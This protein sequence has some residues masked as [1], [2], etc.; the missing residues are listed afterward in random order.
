MTPSLER[1]SAG[2][3]AAVDGAEPGLE[4]ANDLCSACVELLGMDGAAVSMIYEGVSRGTFG[5]SGEDGRRLDEYQFTFGEGPCLDAVTHRRS[6]LAPDLDAPTE[7]RWPLFSDAALTDGVRA[8][9]ALPIM[10]TSACVGALD[11]FRA[12]PG[13]WHGEQAAGAALAA[14]LASQPLL[15]L[16]SADHAGDEEPRPHERG[17]VTAAD[18]D[19]VEVYQAT[20]ILIAQLDVD[21]AEAAVRLRAH[22]MAT[23]QTASEV[24][25]AIIER[26][27]LLERDGGRG[28]R[29]GGPA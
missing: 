2:L 19:R 14:R 3:R 25:I 13:E 20:G 11:L 18:M 4:A 8:V 27:L 15:D 6:V 9:F 16:L 12:E 7:T 26:R 28:H 5:A 24:G 23:G 29:A 10:I 17:T 22:A 21:A 1:L